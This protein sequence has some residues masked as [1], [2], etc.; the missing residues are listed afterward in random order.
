MAFEQQFLAARTQYHK[1]IQ[2]FFPSKALMALIDDPKPKDLIKKLDGL[3]GK[4]YREM[5]AALNV[6]DA[7]RLVY[8]QKITAQIAHESQADKIRPTLKFLMVKLDKFSEDFEKECEAQRKIEMAAAAKAKAE[9]QK[10]KEEKD[11]KVG[12]PNPVVLKGELGKISEEYHRR[13]QKQLTTAAAVVSALQNIRK[14]IVT[15]YQQLEKGVT[16]A[17]TLSKSGQTRALLV[18]KTNA[19]SQFTI[20]KQSFKAAETAYEPVKPFL[21][22]PKVT[23][24][25]IAKDLR[26]KLP[27][28]AKKELENITK[29]NARF[30]ADGTKRL[31]DAKH[32][33]EDCMEFTKRGAEMGTQIAKLADGKVAATK[34]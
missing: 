33:L 29:A 3:K 9:A 22:P 16:Q 30:F 15:A 12:G 27:P 34:V 23:P 28:S 13:G 14:R 7:Y 17:E 32:L 4:P 10:L 2:N 18:L 11:A 5:D 26:F 6:F 31:E 8:L 24:E 25:L 21:K 1:N 19:V 20:C